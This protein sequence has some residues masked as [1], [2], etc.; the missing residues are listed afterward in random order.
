M[1]PAHRWISSKLKRRPVTVGAPRCS[2]CGKDQLAGAQGRTD[3]ASVFQV[4]GLLRVI[5]IYPDVEEALA[6]GE[7][8]PLPRSHPD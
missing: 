1:P 6:A 3:G 4:T 8:P 2:L 7:V 5:Q